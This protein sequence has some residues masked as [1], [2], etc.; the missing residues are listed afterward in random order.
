M[1]RERRPR[2]SKFTAR[3]LRQM[4]VSRERVVRIVRPAKLAKGRT[5]PGKRRRGQD[6]G[7]SPP[8]EG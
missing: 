3:E 4:G 7:R 8:G 1:R 5:P 6:T 2:G